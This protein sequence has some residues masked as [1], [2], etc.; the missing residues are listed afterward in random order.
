MTSQKFTTEQAEEQELYSLG[1]AIGSCL[2]LTDGF[3]DRYCGSK[4][5]EQL[6]R[7]STALD[8]AYALDGYIGEGVM[9]GYTNT[10]CG[11]TENDIVIPV[12]EI[13]VQFDG[14]PEEF[15][16]T[17]EDWTINGDLAYLCIDGA[18]LFAIDVDGL[19]ETVDDILDN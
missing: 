15:F 3:I 7:L 16:E 4:V 14:K 2:E 17:P 18:A 10:G 9:V 11:A 12:G 1:E 13:E 19:R 8:R 5:R 6:K